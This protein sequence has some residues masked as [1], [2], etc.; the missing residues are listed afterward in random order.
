MKEIRYAKSGANLKGQVLATSIALA[1]AQMAAVAHAD[2]GVG[3]DTTIGNALNLRP[4][5]TTTHGSVPD[6][7]GI[8]AGYDGVARSPIGQMYERPALPNAPGGKT[9]GGWEY[10]G[11]VEAGLIGTSGDDKA[12]GFKRYKDVDNGFILNSFGLNM[13][14]KDS[15]NFFELTGGSVGRD[16]QFYGMQFGRY[17]DWKVSA[18]LNETPHVFTTS[19][20][21]IHNGIGTGN[22]TL[23]P[24]LTPGGSAA[25]ADGARADN[26][27]VAAVANANAGTE[28]DLV[29][30]KGGARFDKTFSDNWKFFASYTKEKRDGARPFSAV[31]GTPGGFPVEI[32]E[33]IDYDSHDLV[34][35][36]NWFDDLNALNL[37]VAAS[38]FR[39]NTST[40][41]FEWP[42]AQNITGAAVNGV[43]A[44]GF[45]NGRF[46]LYPNNDYYN[47]KGEYARQLPN[48]HKG[49]FTASVAFASSR[50]DDDL[51][52]YSIRPVDIATVAGGIGAENWHTTDSLSQTS[53]NAKIDTKLINLGLLLNPTSN[54]NVAGKLRYYETKNSTTFLNCNRNL[55]YATDPDAN[56]SAG[57]AGTLSAYGCSGVWGRV[58]ADGQAAIAHNAGNAY[59]RNIPFDYKRFNY[60][61][62]GNYRVN[63]ANNL[64]LSYEREEYQRDN[65]EREKTWEDK[66]KLLHINRSF[67]NANLRWSFEHD[68]RR[69]SEY[70][71]H[72]PYVS[73][74]SGYLISEPTAGNITS[75]VVH[76]NNALRKYELADRDQN[77]LHARGNFMLRADLDLG[78]SAQLKDI[79]YTN[80]DL[81]RDQQNQQ[82]LNFD[83]TYQ[84]TIERSIYGFYSYQQS[85]LKQ[86]GNVGA[87]G[88]CTIGT[89]GVTVDNAEEFC[90]S[91]G[92][93]IWQ[94]ANAWAATHRDYTDVIG[95]GW[96]E[97]FGD[98]KFDFNYS[99]ANG[100]TK[101]GY[102]TPGNIGAAAPYAG[103]GFETLKTQSH[104]LDV[105]LLVPINKN[106]TSR[107]LLRHEVGKIKDWHYNGL[108]NTPVA[109]NAAA[110]NTLPTAVILDAGPQDYNATLIGV[111]FNFK[112]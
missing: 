27:A 49:K 37:Q 10:T 7:D 21:A 53:A 109:V 18:F 58:Y 73:F 71:T 13:E 70:E 3:Q 6:P 104:Y 63:R 94:T 98:K 39:N 48:F 99:F 89:A 64:D 20:R 69:G 62:S 45:T 76:M 65:R 25:S 66:I 33:P 103:D 34:A 112:L 60:G 32:V 102:D 43:A 1:L 87:S 96:R 42:Y 111:L 17:N 50:Q 68:R 56:S 72:H 31:M 85:K 92:G 4:L 19:Y 30:S 8:G 107:F 95:F 40:L 23:K 38:W 101:I 93:P 100:R 67:E 79:D 88:T 105:N 2:S 52:P 74:Y 57:D 29:R 22:L 47:I 35:G 106:V 78:V 15:A 83:L 77:V 41:T 9:A 16:D 28:L 36:L 97:I 84:P 81:G 108:Q 11:H 51:I 75:W 54:L 12:Q 61:L 90:P 59:I 5:D 24:G 44:T 91:L 14:K 82:T 55:T 110:A 26:Q 80:S 86:R 46:D